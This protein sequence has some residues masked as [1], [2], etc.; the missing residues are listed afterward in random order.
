M[1]VKVYERKEQPE[2]GHRMML[3]LAEQIE[4]H[5]TQPSPAAQYRPNFFPDLLDHGIFWGLLLGALLGVALAWLVQNGRVTPT[6]WEGLFS[7]V[8]FSFYAFFAFAGAASGLLL[9]GMITLLAAPVPDMDAADAG[10][11]GMAV[12][13]EEGRTVIER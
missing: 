13:E 10:V 8:P 12:V 11:G 3:E 5:Y 9:G 2:D 4:D 1:S 6:G 7:L